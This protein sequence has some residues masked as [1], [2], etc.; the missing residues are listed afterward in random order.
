MNFFFFCK[1]LMYTYCQI[2]FEKEL[3]WFIAVSS[4]QVSIF[5]H[6]MCLIENLNPF[7]ALICIC[8]IPSDG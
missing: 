2:G 1:F 3:Y 8:L 5:L 4:I 7:V 6:C